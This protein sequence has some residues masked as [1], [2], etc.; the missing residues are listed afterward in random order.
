[1][2][3][4]PRGGGRGTTRGPPSR[5][6]PHPASGPRRAPPGAADADDVPARRR[7]PHPRPHRRPPETRPDRPRARPASGDVVMTTS[8]QSSATTVD[9][10][11]P[12]FGAAITAV[13]LLIDVFLGA[14]GATTGA[15]VLLAALTALFGWGAFA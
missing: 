10:R 5:G 3:S 7:R 4:A 1:H 15:A 6:R 2:R 13:L 14:A 9:P 8:V 12:R 11:A